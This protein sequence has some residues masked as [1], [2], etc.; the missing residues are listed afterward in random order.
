MTFR[1][2]GTTGTAWIDG[3]PAGGVIEAKVAVVK[4]QMLEVGEAAILGRPVSLMNDYE[5]SGKIT[6]RMELDLP[7][8]MARLLDERERKLRA[9]L[10]VLEEVAPGKSRWVVV[11]RRSPPGWRI[12]VDFRTRGAALRAIRKGKV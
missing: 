7:Q 2:S 3:R 12:L 8:Y 9:R 1:R 11:S 10:P 4:E 6:Y 5:A